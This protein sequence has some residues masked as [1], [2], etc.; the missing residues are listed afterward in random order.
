MN[1]RLWPLMLGVVTLGTVRAQTPSFPTP[2]DQLPETVPAL[3]LPV[4][5]MG[6]FT[7]GITDAPPAPWQVVR[8]S[9]TVPPTR[10]R[11]RVW[12]GVVAIEAEAEASMALLARPLKVDLTQTPVLCWRWR[13]DAPL[14]TA[15]LSRKAG[16]DYAARVYVAFRLPPDALGWSL[17]TQIA[18]AR[19]LF[20]A[21]VPDA[22]LNY[23]WDNRHPVGFDAPSPYTDRTRLI[24][25]QSGAA[26]AGRWV[27]ERH[28]VLA[29]A[30]RAFGDARVTPTLLAV[31]SDTDN[32]GES[33]RAGFADLHFVARDAPCQFP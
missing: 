5:S 17:R 10:Y 13:I 15:D 8:L 12:D 23:I 25:A 28:D 29:D 27:E 4:Q 20:G 11:V 19:R 16:D 14:Q 22:A 7:G 18:L 1:A 9:D 6:R 2:V 3:S 33:A 21:N 31:A 30:V 32:T 24:V 26:H